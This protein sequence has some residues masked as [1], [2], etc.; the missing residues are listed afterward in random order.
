MRGTCKCQFDRGAKE[1]AQHEEQKRKDRI[2]R[3]FAVAELGP[4]FEE[5]SFESWV[6]R[7]GAERCLEAAKDYVDR[8]DERL[9]EGQGLLFF[10]RPGNG[11]SHLAAAIV[12][13]LVAAGRTCVF[14]STP[15]LLKKLQETYKPEARLTEAEI[16]SVLQ[17][18][19]LLVLDDLGAEKM[20]EWAESM[21]YYVIDQRYRWRRPLIATTNSTLEALE[22]HVSA[23]SF[24]R[25]LEMCVLVENQASS[26]RRERAEV[27]S[28]RIRKVKKES[29]ALV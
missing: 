1:E 15:A 9:K 14:R 19:D 16:L 2:E 8:F 28:E 5:C 22:D 6:P 7:P 27:R 21:L 25:L 3:L 18:A 11:K 23:R 24:D 20:T 29:G 13:A 4:R 10:G 12:N 26:Y 17:E